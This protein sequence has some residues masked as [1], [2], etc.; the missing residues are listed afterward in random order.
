MVKKAEERAYNHFVYLGS[1]LAKCEEFDFAVS[2]PTSPVCS[3]QAS[4]KW[5]WHY[6]FLNVLIIRTPCFS[7]Q[8]RVPV[9]LWVER[10][11]L[12]L[13]LGGLVQRGTAALV[14]TYPLYSHGG[15]F[16]PPDTGQG[17]KAEQVMSSSLC[18][19]S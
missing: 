10:G 16:N 5:A 11:Q 12:C 3:R 14:G 18:T 19:S 17:W 8:Q 4:R 15:L 7:C 6:G 2:A 1:L 13:L 9:M